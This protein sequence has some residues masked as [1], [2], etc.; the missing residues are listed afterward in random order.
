[1]VDARTGVGRAAGV[2]LSSGVP[3]G[4]AGGVVEQVTCLRRREV[5]GDRLP[6][7]VVA[8]TGLLVAP[9]ALA[10]HASVGSAREDPAVAGSKAGDRAGDIAGATGGGRVVR[11]TVGRVVGVVGGVGDLVPGGA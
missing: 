5:V 11:V 7:G 2:R 6:G 8:A 10:E 1:T 9:E 4:V 3:E